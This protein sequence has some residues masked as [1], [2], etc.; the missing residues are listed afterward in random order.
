MAPL[1]T[2][3]KLGFGRSAEVAAVGPSGITATGGT[4]TTPG[5]GYTYHFFTAPG[6]FIVTGS[7][8]VEYVVVAG[9]GAAGTINGRGAGG[10]GA[11]G[12]RTGT[13][14]VTVATTYPVTIGNGG[15]PAPTTG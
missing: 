6:N 10:G 2:G 11:G 3:L 5:N 15:S 12:F 13:T 1:F 7:G 9:C 8:S 4:I 14:P